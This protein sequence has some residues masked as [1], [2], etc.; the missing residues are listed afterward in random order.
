MANNTYSN[1]INIKEKLHQGAHWTI[2]SAN[3]PGLFLGG[4][5]LKALRNDIPI[6]IK[7]L[8]RMN[9]GMDV[10]VRPVCST[11]ANKKH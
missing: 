11:I 8:Y 4:K 3:L 2:T 9:H 6:A 1:I 7:S 5:D 10:E